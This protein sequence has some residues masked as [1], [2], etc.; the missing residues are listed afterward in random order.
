MV[1]RWYKNRAE[2]PASNPS[3]SSGRTVDYYDLNSTPQSI[4]TG[5]L[6]KTL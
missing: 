3:T 2:L 1:G 5:K 6:L 4:Y